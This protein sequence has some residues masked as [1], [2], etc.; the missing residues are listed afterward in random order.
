M[1]FYS[2]SNGVATNFISWNIVTNTKSI[3][4]GHTNDVKNILY[5]NKTIE[6]ISYGSDNKII[7]WKDQ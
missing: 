5:N 7:I 6:I 2:F 1:N 4:A 3:L